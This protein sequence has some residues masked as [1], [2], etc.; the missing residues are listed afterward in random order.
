MPDLPTNVGM[1]LLSCLSAW[2]LG[3]A[4]E[5]QVVMLL[6]RMLDTVEA[7]PKWNG[8]LYNWYNTRLAQPM[9]PAYIS[10]VDSGNLVRLPDRS[11]G[12][13]P[14]KRIS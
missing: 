14:G 8:H 11:V 2:D 7:L 4:K 6:S 3:L 10:T 1:A 13:T 12:R 9:E 5:R